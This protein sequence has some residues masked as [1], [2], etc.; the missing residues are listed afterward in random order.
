M[1]ENFEGE[2]KSEKSV[3]SREGRVIGPFQWTETIDGKEIVKEGIIR[4]AK[5]E[6]YQD[7]VEVDNNRSEFRRKEY[8]VEPKL[9]GEIEKVMELNLERSL[10]QPDELAFIVLEVEGEI[11]GYVEFGKMRW[12]VE[13][14]ANVREASTVS[15]LEKYHGKGIG[16]ALTLSAEDEVR[17]IGVE[18]IELYT[19]DQNKQTVG[20]KGRIG[21]YEKLGYKQEGEPEEDEGGTKWSGKV[22]KYIKFV[23]YLNKQK[24]ENSY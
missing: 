24:N 5:K 7:L 10:S 1:P 17:K 8:G 19:N 12:G 20:S 14:P 23:K 3:E 13:L 22:I 18:K 15:V 16:T 6:D 2:L 4:Y 21:F 9:P 11:A